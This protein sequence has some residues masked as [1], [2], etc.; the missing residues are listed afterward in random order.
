M[1]VQISPS[2][3][4]LDTKSMIVYYLEYY[5]DYVHL[6][7]YLPTHDGMERITVGKFPKEELEYDNVLE[8]L[9]AIL[10]RLRQ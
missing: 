8:N 5:G 3:A 9:D 7:T 10:E 2:N 4:Y 1:I 6:C